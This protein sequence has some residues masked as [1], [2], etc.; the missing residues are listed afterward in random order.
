MI[1]HSFPQSIEAYYQESGRAGR[2]GLVAH[3]ILMYT[4][5][6]YNRLLKLIEG[7]RSAS[8]ALH[9]QRLQ[10]VH[11]MVAYCE[12]VAVCRRKLLVEHF[13]EVSSFQEI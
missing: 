3:C 7:D 1:H 5:T 2:D 8:A 9:A 10:S 11:L 6:D 13:G 12:S 4:F